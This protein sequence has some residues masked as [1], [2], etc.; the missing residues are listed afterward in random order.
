MRVL[1]EK[2]R[3]GGGARILEYTGFD[4]GSAPVYGFTDE[5]SGSIDSGWVTVS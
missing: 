1:F 5:A 3:F 4:C 2:E